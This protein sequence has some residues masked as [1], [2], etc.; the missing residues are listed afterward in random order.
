MTGELNALLITAASIGFFHTLLG[1]DH[2]LPF[3]MMS[4][5]RKWSILKT[6][7]I[8][9]LCGVGHIA[10]SVV[11]GFIGV[12]LGLAV[13][14]LEVVESNRGDVAAW[15]LIG[16]GLAYFVWGVRRAW[17]NKP[18]THTHLHIDNEH[19]HEHGHAEEHV[20]MHEKASVLSITPWALFVIFVFGPC[21]PLIPIL[22]YPA[23]K[24]SMFDVVLVTI[25]F[26]S[27]TIAT[28]MAVV[29][30]SIAGV[31]FTRLARLQRYSHAVAGATICLCGLAIVFLGL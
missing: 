11:L 18:H 5:A 7:V 31:S 22:M 25:V 9:F 27:V 26:G 14:S 30:L 15:L 17:R 21:E 20:H 6:S 1:P 24:N 10:S 16:F 8:T 19:T 2:Y 12:S 13:R 29:L 28:M 4:W 23:A 3:I